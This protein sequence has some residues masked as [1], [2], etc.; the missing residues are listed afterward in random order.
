MKSKYTNTTDARPTISYLAQLQSIK[1]N[2]KQNRRMKPPKM[3]TFGKFVQK[4]FIRSFATVRK[5]KLSYLP[6]DVE[7]DSWLGVIGLLLATA[8]KSRVRF[9]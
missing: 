2:L 8:Y 4:P 5:E 1:S 9:A 3:S 7:Y 6:K